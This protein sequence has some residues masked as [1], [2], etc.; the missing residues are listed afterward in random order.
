VL[1]RAISGRESSQ[2]GLDMR[3]R[4]NRLTRLSGLRIVD[5]ASAFALFG[6]CAGDDRSA[7]APA[8][9][10]SAPKPLTAT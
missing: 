6:E 4:I 5:I 3:H 7:K 2:L 9:Q 8:A 10:D 1:A